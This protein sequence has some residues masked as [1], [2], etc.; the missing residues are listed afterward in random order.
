[1]SL[2]VDIFRCGCRSQGGL[3]PMC[4]YRCGCRCRGLRMSMSMSMPIIVNHRH[5]C[6]V[7]RIIA[8]LPNAFSVMVLELALEYYLADT[9]VA[10][11]NVAAVSRHLN[12]T[13]QNELRKRWLRRRRRRAA[14]EAAARYIVCW[15]CQVGGAHNRTL[16]STTHSIH[17]HSNVGPAHTY[18]FRFTPQA[19]Q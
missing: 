10:V 11:L 5:V 8:R 1:M 16:A 12:I 2:S 18:C 19:K 6:I 13:C 9:T 14:C 4:K 3:F 17:T 15:Q 7:S